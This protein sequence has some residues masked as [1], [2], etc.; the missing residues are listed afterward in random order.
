[1]DY[2]RGP[3]VIT[4]VRIRRGSRGEGDVMRKGGREWSQDLYRWNEEVTS[5][6]IHVVTKH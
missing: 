2:L 5:Q 6:R 3:H 4:V 1:M